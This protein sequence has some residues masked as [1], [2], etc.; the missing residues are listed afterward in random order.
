MDAQQHKL[1][2]FGQALRALSPEFFAMKIAQSAPRKPCAD[3]HPLRR[4]LRLSLPDINLAEEAR[5]CTGLWEL[6]SRP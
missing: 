5:S 6:L 3:R 1:R 4:C 2:Q